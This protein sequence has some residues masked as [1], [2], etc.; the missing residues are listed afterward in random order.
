ME[1]ELDNLSNCITIMETNLKLMS[2]EMKQCKKRYK[3]IA[4]EMVKLQKKNK[5][6]G[7]RVRSGINRPR[8]VS[9]SMCDFM[10]LPRGSS[11][12]R[13]DATVAINAYIRKMKLQDEENKRQFKIDDELQKLFKAGDREY[14]TY[15]EIPKLMNI[16]FIREPVDT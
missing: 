2:K 4:S 9:E 1:E 13:T 11:I 3:K 7:N 8:L 12:A 15:F 5:K 6:N 16:H 10:K 14:V